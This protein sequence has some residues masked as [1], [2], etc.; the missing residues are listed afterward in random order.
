[1]GLWV[2][3]QT[4]AQGLAPHVRANAIGLGPSLVAEHQAGRQFSQERAA[5]LLGRGAN[6]N[7]ITAV[8]GYLLKARSVTEN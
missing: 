1:M 8:L 3:T 5:T 4:A 6:A 2:L 7:D